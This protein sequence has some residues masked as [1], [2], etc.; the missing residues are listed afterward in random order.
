MRARA[1]TTTDIQDSYE[2]AA[3]EH[4]SENYT[5]RLEAQ[6]G[7][8]LACA[9]TYISLGTTTHTPVDGKL[10]GPLKSRSRDCER[11]PVR[12]QREAE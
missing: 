2:A 8:V 11:Y 3:A 5:T 6:G 12:T 7:E 10:E 4:R 1:S 9:V